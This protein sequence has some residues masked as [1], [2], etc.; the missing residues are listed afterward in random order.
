[1]DE[2]VQQTSNAPMAPWPDV[3][4]PATQIL[5]RSVCVAISIGKFGTR[6]K[7]NSS[8][9]TT[10]ADPELI[11]ISKEILKSAQYD[12]IKSL[13]G[14]ARKYFMSRALPFPFKSGFYLIPIDLIPEVEARMALFER[15]RQELIAAFVEVYPDLVTQAQLRLGSLFDPRDYPP[16]ERVMAAF[17]WD[18]R[19]VDVGVPGKLRSIDE[20]LF[21]SQQEKIARETAKA[22]EAGQELLRKQMAEFVSRLVDRLSGKDDGNPKTFKNTAVTKLQDWLT[23]FD[24]RNSVVNDDELQRLADRAK[25]LISGVEPATLRTDAMLREVTQKGFAEINAQL[26]TMMVDRPKRRIILD[27]DEMDR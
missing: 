15:E 21:N 3:P 6:R 17:Q 7:V 20:A 5:D 27:E 18:R 26:D 22:V 4:A 10:D 12:A 14:R 8:E 25:A 2:S 13:D 11:H 16:A 23:V 9:V 1:M 24:A 19:Y